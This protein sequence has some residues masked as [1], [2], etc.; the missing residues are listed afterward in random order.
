MERE[1][2]NSQD[3]LNERTIPYHPLEQENGKERPGLQKR[4]IGLDRATGSL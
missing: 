2:S 4:A 1:P 3:L